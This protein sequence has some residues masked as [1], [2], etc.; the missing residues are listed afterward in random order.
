MLTDSRQFD[1]VLIFFG[2]LFQ[3][4]VTESNNV[5]RYSLIDHDPPQKHFKDLSH[6]QSEAS[7]HFFTRVFDLGRHASLQDR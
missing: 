4:R 3:L 6:V 5:E 1:L 7:Q 2:D